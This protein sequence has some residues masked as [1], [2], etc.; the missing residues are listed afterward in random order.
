MIRT[1]HV[2][3]VSTLETCSADGV[4]WKK[5]CYSMKEC[6]LRDLL[7]YYEKSTCKKGS[8]MIRTLVSF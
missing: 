3:S 2:R 6:L 7:Y 4:H 8:K 5:G 1:L